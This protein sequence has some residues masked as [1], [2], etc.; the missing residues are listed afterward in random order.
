[1][2][3]VSQAVRHL[4][5]KSKPSRPSS[6]AAA[7]AAH[8]DLSTT[9]ITLDFEGVGNFN[10]VLGYYSGMDGGP[11][12]GV[13]FGASSIAL[14]D[15]DAGGNGGFANEPSPNTTLTFI[16]DVD[17]TMSVPAGFTGLSFQYTSASDATISV[18]AGPN[19]TGA[20]LAS[21]LVPRTG[22]CEEDGFPG[23]FPFCGDPTGFLGVWLS[24][25]VPFTGVAKSISFAAPPGEDLVIIFDDMVIYQNGPPPPPPCNKTTYWLWNPTTNALV[26]ELK[27]NSASCF[28]VP[29]NIE[30]RPCARPKKL[31]VFLS[32]IKSTFA[33][34]QTKIE[35]VAPYFLW[36]DN[37]VTG[38]VFPNLKPLP[39]GTYWLYSNVGGVFERIKFTKTC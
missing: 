1:V 39:K 17:T 15:A 29:Y 10:Q 12:Y 36:G 18:F 8:R 24:Y 5:L 14:V 28:S 2:L 25:A 35:L 11:N 13:V 23:D 21:A 6:A 34:I 32:L 27:N 30:V 7:A 37:K 16:D 22:I 38:D 4:L 26:G 3:P 31:P 33:P 20:V 9:S 19:G